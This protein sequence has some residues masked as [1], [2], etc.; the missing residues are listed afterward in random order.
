MWEGQFLLILLTRQNSKK[1]L[2][3]FEEKDTGFYKSYPVNTHD[4]L[5]IHL[6]RYGNEAG[7]HKGSLFIVPGRTESA[8]KYSEV[9]WDLIQ[10][11]Y[12]PIFAVDHRGQGLSDR[13][14]EDKSKG[15][16]RDFEDYGRDLNLAVQM[17]QELKPSQS[18][19]HLLAHSM[20][21]AVS[22]LYLQNYKTPFKKVILSSP[23][24]QIHENRVAHEESTLYQ[25][26]ALCALP[27]LNLCQN[28]VP[29]GS[30]YDENIDQF[31]SSTASRSEERYIF[32][33]ALWKLFPSL[34]NSSPT[35]GWVRQAILG[36]R[37]AR[38]PLNLKKMNHYSILLLQAGQETF[39]NNDQQ[40][41]VCKYL[42]RCQLVSFP[43]ARHEILMDLDSTRS[44]ALRQIDTFFSP[45]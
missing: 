43:E 10:M 13:H 28:Y 32:R 37:K 40:E 18:P 9:A 29:G 30:P 36:T 31:H 5:T 26:W 16:V 12:G 24:F 4:G 41:K 39:V 42:S 23:M 44:K 6:T 11:G 35:L 38:A 19:L 22:A 27:W 7:K 3:L 45:K 15:H 2:T 14:L 8:F 17:A 20:G 33:K 25:T 1:I 34:R 21:G